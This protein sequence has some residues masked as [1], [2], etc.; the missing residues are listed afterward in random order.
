[1]LF[2]L[3][4]TELHKVPATILSRCQRFA[5]RR[6]GQEDIAA[7]L[8]YVAYQEGIDLDDSAA[9]V[10]ARLADGGMR[11]GLSLLD[12]CASATTGEL[13]DERV[14][15]CLGIAGIQQCGNLMRHI[16][17]H[18]TGK[19]LNLLNTFY[20][21]GKDMGALLDEMA[22]LTR[23]FL[24][25]KTAPREGIGMLSGVASDQETAALS[26]KFSNGELVRMLD[27][28]QQTA[29]GFTRSSSRRLDAELCIVNLC[30][31]DL[32]L[33][34]QALNA[35]LTRLE[36]QLRSGTFT[37]MQKQPEEPE[38]EQAPPPDDRDAPPLPDEIPVPKNEETP[39]GFW[40]DV[41]S[42]VRTEL[43]PPA[44]GFFAPTPNAPIQA[45]LQGNQLMLVCA[46][47][48]TMGMINKPEILELV[49]R[50]ASA[51]LGRPIRV[52][53]VD[54]S[55]GK[56]NSEQMEQLLRFGRAH[57]DIINIKE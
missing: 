13:T 8:Q 26:Q 44:S 3:A 17:D 23:D 33:D 1:L 50:K 12:Q 34:A 55:T 2:I 10:L 28:I 48:F 15:A 25:L 51:K 18:D 46:N 49:S 16:A 24:I 57:S 9:R 37:V 38:E 7:R 11:D 6:I 39:I 19:A 32:N 35:R 5:F 45:R 31:P 22:C 42:Q 40:T 56:G 53:L 52:S 29:A 21:E 27:L 54:Q 43:K 30:Q 20:A 36:D 14:Y 47:S 41:A 4:T